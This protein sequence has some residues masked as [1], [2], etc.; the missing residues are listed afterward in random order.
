MGKENKKAK[1]TAEC[2]NNI[3]QIELLPQKGVW[4]HLVEQKI[5]ILCHQHMSSWKEWID[6]EVKEDYMYYLF[7]EQLTV[8]TD[9]D[10]T[11]D[12]I[13]TIYAGHTCSWQGHELIGMLYEEF[14][15]LFKLIPEEYEE[16]VY[17]SSPGINWRY[18]NI[19]YFENLGF[20]LWVWRKRIRHMFIYDPADR[21]DDEPT[22]TETD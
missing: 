7:N 5:P 22:A 13:S 8:W 9:E 17:N 10:K 3:I 16:H 11:K 20:D 2:I 19:Y 21:L 1:S 15:E 18:Y 14:Q 6:H 4:V 12:R